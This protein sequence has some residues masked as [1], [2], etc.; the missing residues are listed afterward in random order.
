MVRARRIS[1]GRAAS[2]QRI[3]QRYGRCSASSR[4][5]ARQISRRSWAAIQVRRSAGHRWSVGQAGQ[6]PRLGLRGPAGAAWAGHPR[7][8]PPGKPASRWLVVQRLV[9]SLLNVVLDPFVQGLPGDLQ[10]SEHLGGFELQAKG[11]GRAGHAARCQLGLVFP[12]GLSPNQA[13]PFPS[14]RL[15]RTSNRPRARR[16]LA[17]GPLRS[18]RPSERRCPSRD[19]ACE[20]ERLRQQGLLAIGVV[21]TPNSKRPCCRAPAPARSPDQEPCSTRPA[22]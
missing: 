4:S 17:G 13:D 11:A 16:H 20:H 15:S 12:G 14:T 1:S 19:L 22:P 18:V 7:L 2:E 21:R 6:Q 5:R 9:W 8:V 3:S 10:G